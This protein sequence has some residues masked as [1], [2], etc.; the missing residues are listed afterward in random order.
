[1]MSKEREGGLTLIELVVAMAIFALMAVMGVQALSGM[2]VQRDALSGRAI[3]ERDLLY[4]TALLRADLRQV[5]P[6]L[7]FPPD[8][9]SPRSAVADRTGGGVGFS[10]STAV[11]RPEGQGPGLG[12]VAWWIDAESG[13]LMRQ[14]WPTLWPA[15]AT[16]VGPEVAVLDGVDGLEM[17]SY[18]G[19][20]GWRPGLRL[21]A[22][23][24]APGNAS[25]GD[26]DQAGAA[27]EAY[28][29][30]LPLA[31]EL[32]LQ[33]RRYGDLVLVETLP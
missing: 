30:L 19:G 28:S 14:S 32:R 15:A 9:A 11:P 31:I 7:F 24:A 6:L 25:E 18:W 27:P 8:G 5:L 16:Q 3:K 22:L 20:F 21:D 1:M 13:R 29:D 2:L 12:R 26:G 17:R 4:A 10:L 23:E 33:T